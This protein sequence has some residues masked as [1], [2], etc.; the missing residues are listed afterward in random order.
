MNRIIDCDAN[1]HGAKR[2]GDPVHITE[3][4]SR[5][6]DTA[7][8]AEP[9]RQSNCQ[10]YRRRAK[11]TQQQQRDSTKGDQR[12]HFHFCTNPFAGVQGEKARAAD[13]G[14]Q[15]LRIIIF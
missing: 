9:Y 3:Y 7:Q 4:P 13:D 14:G 1:H 8:Q 15:R 2:D 5:Y 12:Q 10:Q 6:E 11:G